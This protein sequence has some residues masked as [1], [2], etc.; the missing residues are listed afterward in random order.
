MTIASESPNPLSEVLFAGGG[1][2]GAL[3][4]SHNWSSTPLGPVENWSPTLRSMVSTMLASR[5]SQT[6]F[7]GDDLIQLYNDACIANYGRNHPK[8][9]GLPLRETWSEIWDDQI[10]PMFK[11][12]KDTGEAV[13][14]EDLLFQLLRFGDLEEAYFTVC[15]SPILDEVGKFSGILCTNTETTQ[16]VIDR[17]RLTM[18]REVATAGSGAKTLQSACTAAADTLNPYDIP[19]TLFY[20]VNS[21]GNLAELVAASGLSADSAAAP[22][23]MTLTPGSDTSNSTEQSQGWLLTEVLQS[24]EPLLMT[25][26]GDRFGVLPGGPWPESPRSA[27]I[28]PILSGSKEQAECL[29]VA[30][31][32]P[33]LQ[34]NSG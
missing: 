11:G 3:M 34:F 15:Y 33:R 14:A 12:I 32:S 31:I 17:R 7:W 13:F 4:R 24:R 8:A 20:Q 2:M 22:P 28:L 19:F 6:I 26:V 16:Q 1:E 25:D 5:F 30:G 10:K 21:E 23:T 27:M 29:L 9:L 18:L